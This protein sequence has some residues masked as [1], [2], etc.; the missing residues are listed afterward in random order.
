MQDSNLEVSDTY[1]PLVPVLIQLTEGWWCKYVNWIIIG[2]DN[3]LAPGWCQAITWTND[4]LLLIRP[5]WTSLIKIRI[6]T[7][8]YI[9]QM[10]S[11]SVKLNIHLISK[12]WCLHML[13][14][15]FMIS[16]HKVDGWRDTTITIKITCITY[17]HQKNW[18]W[19]EKTFDWLVF[20]EQSYNPFRSVFLWKI[21]VVKLLAL[22]AKA[23]PNYVVGT[24]IKQEKKIIIKSRDDHG[25]EKF[26]WNHWQLTKVKSFL[27][28][29]C[30]KKNIS[31]KHLMTWFYSLCRYI[32]YIIYI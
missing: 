1:A 26:P 2:S 21:N 20:T 8:K 29:I 4:H 13:W 3:G 22:Q 24:K 18:V 14:C 27:I 10:S 25:C 19:T 31:R 23:V 9:F 15:L 12:T 17:F 6:K 28:F 16:S 11:I 5:I 7:H 32:I 30:E